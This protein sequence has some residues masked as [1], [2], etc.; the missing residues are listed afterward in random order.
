[1]SSYFTNL[2]G[3]SALEIWP[4]QDLGRLW[5]H[6]HNGNGPF[7]FVM[8]FRDEATGEKQYKR[9]RKVPVERAIS[10]ALATVQGRKKPEKSL[11]FVP[12][13]TNSEQMWRWGGFDFDAHDGDSERPRRFAFDGVSAPAQL[14]VRRDPRKQRKRRLAYVGYR[15]RF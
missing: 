4:V 7:D 14:R 15:A 8:G 6:L 3:R 1:M 9:S 2:Q 13:S 11:A 12:Y 10:W 5:Q